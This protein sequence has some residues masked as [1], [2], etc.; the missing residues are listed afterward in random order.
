MFPLN[1]MCAFIF[2]FSSFNVY[3]KVL[4]VVACLN[5]DDS[6]ACQSIA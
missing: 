4:G 6:F 5:C 1:V 2:I 3:L